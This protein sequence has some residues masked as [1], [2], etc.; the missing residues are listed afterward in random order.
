MPDGQGQTS[1]IDLS[2]L[3]HIE[4]PGDLFHHSMEILQVGRF[5]TTKE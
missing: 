1:N 3:D 2:S 5:T 4:V